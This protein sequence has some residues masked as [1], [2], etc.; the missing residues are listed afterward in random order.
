MDWNASA[1]TYINY[2][3]KNLLYFENHIKGKA[4]T[5]KG[6]FQL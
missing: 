2:E 5:E 3:Y 6:G 4:Q 1:A